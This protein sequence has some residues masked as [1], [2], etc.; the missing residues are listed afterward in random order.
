M[1]PGG[2]GLCTD[3]APNHWALAGKP[4]MGG[5]G[6]HRSCSV[7]VPPSACLRSSQHL[8]THPN[9]SPQP[10]PSTCSSP[11]PAGF[12]PM[13]SLYLFAILADFSRLPFV[14]G[15]S[16]KDRGGQTVTAPLPSSPKQLGL[17]SPPASWGNQGPGGRSSA[18]PG[19]GWGSETSFPH[20]VSRCHPSRRVTSVEGTGTQQGPPAGWDPAP[21]ASCNSIVTPP[22]P[23]LGPC[24]G[25]ATS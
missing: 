11:P 4:R 5:W 6:V 12:H 14:A 19:W 23:D 18:G 10:H 7:R 3:P 20:A 2:G 24:W 13:A 8:L 22:P 17:P 9:P 25:L 16:L 15:G 1:R 21:L